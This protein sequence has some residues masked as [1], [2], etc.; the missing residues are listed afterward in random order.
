MDQHIKPSEYPLIAL[1]PKTETGVTNFL[2]RNP[3]YDGRGVVIAIFDSG[4]D[5]GAPGLRETTTGLP[6]VIER[7]DCSG[8]GDVD[9]SAVVTVSTDGTI[10][11]ASGKVIQVPKT[12]ECP[13]GEFHVGVKP[14]FDLYPAK[15]R[16]RMEAF[17]KEVNWDP[18]LRNALSSSSR[19]L[20]GDANNNKSS[21]SSSLDDKYNKEDIEAQV[22]MLST[23]DKNVARRVLEDSRFFCFDEARSTA[24]Y[25]P[26]NT[27]LNGVAPGAQIAS[28][29]IGDGRLNTMETGTALVRAMAHVMRNSDKYHV[30][31]MSY[32]EHAHWSAH[33]RLGELMKEVVD[34]YGITW[35]ASAGNHG[36]ALSTVGTPPWVLSNTIIG[37]G[38][39]VSPDMMAAE[40]S[41]REKLPGMPY[42]WSSRGP[43]LDGDLG[44]SVCAPGGAI[45]SVPGFTL[46]NSQLMNGTSQ[47]A[48]HVAGCVALMLS[49][50][51][52]KPFGW[53][54]YSVKRSLQ[55]SALFLPNKEPFAQGHGLVRLEEAFGLLESYST[56]LDRDVRFNI[57]VTSAGMISGW[58]LKGI[59]IRDPPLN[60]A[61]EFVVSVDPVFFQEDSIDPEKKINFRMN[62]C[63]LSNVHWVQVPKYFDLANIQRTF[64]V[65]VDTEGLAP[66]VYYSRIEA[67]DTQNM[68]NGPVF[69]VHVTVVRPTNALIAPYFRP[70]VELSNVAYAPGDV[71]R[72]FVQVPKGASWASLHLRLTGGINT[73]RFVVHAMSLVQGFSCTTE[74]YY[75]MVSLQPLE[76]SNLAFAVTE[77][78]TL[79]LVIARWWAESN[80][81]ATLSATLS[82]RSVTVNKKEVVMSAGDAYSKLVVTNSFATEEIQPNVT[83]KYQVQLLRPSDVKLNALPE[84]RD[85]IPNNRGIYELI[86]TYSFTLSRATEITIN[87][88]LLSDT[89]YEC[90]YESQLWMLFDSNKRYVAS[91][92]AYPSKWPTK[93]D[94]GD[95]ILR[96]SIRHEKREALEKFL[97]S[98]SNNDSSSSVASWNGDSLIPGLPLLLSMKLPSNVSLD[99]YSSVYD[100]QNSN[101]SKKSVIG[102]VT[103][104]K[105]S[106]VN[107]FI[108]SFINEKSLKNLPGSSTLYFQGT[109][110]TSKDDLGKKVSTIG[111][112][113]CVPEAPP[114][115]KSS[116]AKDSEKSKVEE[117]EEQIRDMTIN[118]MSKLPPDDA[119]RIYEE[120][121][122]KHNSHLPVHVA[123]LSY[124]DNL[125]S[126]S[127][128]QGAGGS[129]LSSSDSPVG[130]DEKVKEEKKFKTKE[131]LEEII[132]TSD[133]ILGMVDLSALLIYYGTKASAS[134]ILA[135]ATKIKQTMDKQR[136]AVVEA[137]VKKGLALAEL[138][139]LIPAQKNSLTEQLDE[140]L[141]EVNKFMEVTDSR[142]LELSVQHAIARGHYGRAVRFLYK[143]LDSDPLKWTAESDKRLID[144][145]KKLGWNM[146]VWNRETIAAHRYPKDFRPF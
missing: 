6:K 2:A 48:P 17:R 59:Y 33:G 71:H 136:N 38:A 55:N 73:S 22:E 26:E 126:S 113:L 114:K 105:E 60:K 121:S 53:S 93:L 35:V 19:K 103:M 76:E 56:A 46:R 15:V 67:F 104:K 16:E 132:A 95:Y 98:S 8:A 23:F 75:K 99:C 78:L 45:T 1:C 5:P 130:E 81:T 89:L 115:V 110:T 120:L 31:N 108:S 64:N 118:W 21:E 18:D 30:I 122:S 65:K 10:K 70:T 27:E 87:C 9:T 143:Q 138:A 100:V 62:L 66:G 94:K 107:V 144:I 116:A 43:T 68:S 124:L 97:G 63:L 4:V 24:G 11:G 83:L 84:P 129:K 117:M 131:I 36:P 3:T 40:Y 82:F 145:F 127:N 51:L 86:S 42:T 79:E 92:D 102:S 146:S 25:F 111:V 41:L 69:N 13:T 34:K 29:S 125:P 90:E 20:N 57:S 106:N 85:V 12:W 54:P 14:I 50:A 141:Q 139:K 47:A 7:Y 91:G 32:G 123:R 49:G 137:L 88:S 128:N 52:E 74:E 142:V 133:K 77:N 112:K 58:P 72:Y 119:K 96:L 101:P 135:D 109:F 140:I 39:Y 37:V 61:K 80:E 44:V 28:F 134:S